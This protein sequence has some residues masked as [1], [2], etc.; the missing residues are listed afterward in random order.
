MA[1]KTRSFAVIG[2]GT[3]GGT[4]ATELARFGNRVLGIDIAEPVAARFA[5]SLAQVLIADGK[6]ENALR[7]AGLEHYDVAIVAIGEDLEAN[8]LCAMNARL[9]GVQTIWAKAMSRTHH[10]ILSKL[11]VDRVIHPEQE[12]GQRIAQVLNNPMIRDYVSLGNGYNMVNVL[13]P[14]RLAGRTLYELKL[15]ERFDV[16]AI[17]LMRGTEHF[18]GQFVNRTLKCDDRL[19]LLGK[20]ADLRRFADSI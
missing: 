9:L 5:D 19:L 20:R 8:I 3:F 16:R 6:D 2:L 17:G 14:E 1:D 15:P 13:V 10:R 11:G 4:V 18:D 7:E 12:I